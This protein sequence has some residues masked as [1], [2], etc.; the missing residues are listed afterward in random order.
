MGQMS[1]TSIIYFKTDMTLEKWKTKLMMLI[2]NYLQHIWY[3]F[4]NKRRGSIS[5]PKTY[6]VDDGLKEN[7][8]LDVQTLKN[9]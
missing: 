4:G 9:F 1:V 7:Y 8:S 6:K 5:S 3:V 2:Q